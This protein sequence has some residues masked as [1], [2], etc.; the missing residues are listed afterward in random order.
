MKVCPQCQSKFTD[1]SL[2]YCLQDGTELKEIIE[3][4]T[5]VFDQGSLSDDKTIAD[6]FIKTSPN[7]SQKTEEFTHKTTNQQQLVDNPSKETVIRQKEQIAPTI[8]SN[9]KESKGSGLS[10]LTGMIVGVLFFGLIG[11]GILGVVF[12]P[13]FIGKNDNSNVNANTANTNTK[14]TRTLTDSTSV[15]VSSSSTR[16]PEKGNFY[17][18]KLAFDGNPRTAWAEGV[19]GAGKGQ[20]IAFDFK[21]EVNLKQI[22]I[23]PGY[24][25]TESLWRKNNRVASAVL[26]FSNGVKHSFTFQDQ[27]KEQKIDIDNVKTKSVMI[28]IKD[29][30]AGQADSEDTLISEVSFV[31]E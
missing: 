12:L 11:I 3:D 16:K 28:T 29:I 14:T 17:N 7:D 23:Q 5:L 4:K 27:M 24:F 6:N 25:K 22:I 18:P 2:K 10:F 9:T 30:Y 31:V 8:V 26:A 1:N 19:R 13:G 21:E 20:W 15:K